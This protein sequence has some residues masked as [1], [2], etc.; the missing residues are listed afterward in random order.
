[1]IQDTALAPETNW[2]SGR[3]GI[4]LPPAELAQR[5]LMLG[6][7]RLETL[8][9]LIEGA[10]TA[11]RRIQAYAEWI[12]ANPASPQRTAAWFNLG[13]EWSAY[14]D[15]A[16][17]ISAYQQALL[18]DPH[19]HPAAVNL[20]LALEALGQHDA[21]LACWTRALQ[22]DDARTVLLNHRG[23][24]LEEQGRLADAEKALVESLLLDPAQPDVIQHWLHIRQKTCS[25]PVVPEGLPG[26]PAAA[27]RAAC[28]PLGGLALVDDPD[29]QRRIAQSWLDRKIAPAPERLSPP[30]GYAHGRI[31]LGYLSSDFCRHAMSFLI[32]EM[33]EMHDRG[34]FEIFGYC[35]SPD[36]GS[37]IRRRVIRALDH[38]VPVRH[39]DD[40]AVARRIREDEI[41]ILV[42]LNGLTKGARL[43]TLR[44]KPAPVQVTYL[45][46]IGSVPLPELDYLICDDYVVPP[47]LRDQYRPA[48]LS[49]PGIYQANDGRSPELPVASRAAEGLPE[50]K[51]VFCCFCSTYKITPEIFDAWMEILRL[52]PDSV[53]WLVCENETARVNLAARAKAATIASH[54]LIFAG[55]AEPGMYLA[56]MAL[57]D[58][59]LDTSPYNAGTVASDALRMGLPLLTL[60]KRSFASRMAGSLLHAMG[61]PETVATTAEEYV[62]KAVSIACS[63]ELLATL[64]ERIGGDR[65]Q[66]TLGDVSGFVTGLEDAYRSIRIQ[67]ESAADGMGAA[68]AE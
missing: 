42:D 32:A 26:L 13:A 25:W 39:L 28:G 9:P 62:R 49:L 47:G 24:L 36:D 54:R 29:E 53:L 65:W 46:Y 16:K 57:G 14:G 40:A 37:D 1:M 17:A 15:K 4:D 33:L 35:S 22:S 23:R 59:F 48:P 45:G 7:M 50:D 41:D 68:A 20:G 56:R 2:L 52:A 38:H 8:L 6:G 58:L 3:L 27:L 61:M 64:R 5:R 18:A 21:A 19:F 63:P 51:F 10:A 67:P 11:L 30:G 60:S 43:H 66:R 31:R 55:R 44:W 34:S 12:T